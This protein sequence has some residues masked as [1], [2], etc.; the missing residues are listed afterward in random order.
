MKI[1]GNPFTVN[2]VHTSGGAVDWKSYQS[3][4]FNFV[5]MISK[6]QRK[7]EMQ[8]VKYYEDDCNFDPHWSCEFFRFC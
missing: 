6:Y 5:R 8:E 1:D 7:H 2:M 4:Q 3:G